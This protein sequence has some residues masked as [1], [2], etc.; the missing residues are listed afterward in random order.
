MTTR[1]NFLRAGA[2]ATG[3]LLASGRVDLST[4]AAAE[5]RPRAAAPLR[6]LVLGG[7]GFIGPHQVRYAVARGH[8]VSIFTRGRRESDLP[9]GI[10]YLTG[11]RN[12]QLDAL[13]G[14]TWDA[15]IDN[16]ATDP[17]WV[18]Q[19]VDVLKDSVG[20]YMYTSSTGVYYPQR[21][22][23]IDETTPVWM[24]MEMPGANEYG[25]NKANSE[26]LVRKGFGDDRAVLI[27][28]HYIVGPGDTTDRFPYWPQRLAR[29]GETLVPGRK[30][31]PVA[32]IDVRDLTEFMIH[33]LEQEKGGTFNCSGPTREVCTMEQFMREATTSISST[34]QLVWV[35]DH[36]FLQAQ[37]VTFAVP[38]V[39]PRTNNTGMSLI[40]YD[41]A[42]EAG[43]TFRP[44][45]D[46]VRDTLAW[47]PQREPAE[48][49]T[50]TPRFSITPE[51]EA[52]ALAAW[53]AR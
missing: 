1:R 49:R 51:R 44:I 36:D 40:R 47:W 19:T 21:L 31:D 30:D 16:S 13:R 27:R 5:L 2:A 35:D 50:A 24:S 28:P 6:I 10:E 4:L 48:R 37:R 26:F 9:D 29:G 20:R 39:L 18:R 22:I 41:R 52:E 53:K 33:L 45:G 3:A 14:R 43:L 46:T 7:T 25:V 11:D 38:W 8:T 42:M 32:M 15:V 12:G 23:G 34:S 17:E